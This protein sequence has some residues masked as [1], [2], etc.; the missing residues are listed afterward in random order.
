MI[1]INLLPDVKQELIR[2]QKVRNTVVSVSII[3]SIVAGAVVVLLGSFVYVAQPLIKDQNAKAIV[4]NHGE[5]LAT[6]DLAE[7]VTIQNQLEMISS[8][9]AQKS[10]SSR[11]FDVLTTIQPQGDNAVVYRN[12][13]VDSVEKTVTIEAEA[14]NG[15]S[16][17][18]AFKKTIEATDF[19]Y[20]PAGAE[21]LE[22]VKLTDKVS[23]GDRTLGEDAEG[24]RVLRFTIS[25]VYNDVLFARDSKQG[26]IIGPTQTNATDSAVA[27]PKSL[28]SGEGN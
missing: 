15:Y 6:P 16:A 24:R 2:A 28:F 13:Q 12:I 19:E 3:T 18:E 14:V 26:K 23:D 8:Q 10:V 5:L 4:K 9:H 25:F 27:V 20:M 1:E 21:E 7:A 17:L 22:K 11:I